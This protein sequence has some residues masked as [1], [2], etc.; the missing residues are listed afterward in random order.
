MLQGR[1]TT[2]GRRS[3]ITRH[4]LESRNG[5]GDEV[6]GR[7]VVQGVEGDKGKGGDTGFR[8]TRGL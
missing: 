1:A 5:S 4:G 6:V 7:L 8:G 2:W 3:R